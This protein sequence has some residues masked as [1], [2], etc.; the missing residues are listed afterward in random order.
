MIAPFRS[1]LDDAEFGHPL[2]IRIWIP[3]SDPDL[4]TQGSVGMEMVASW[5][6]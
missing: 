1:G 2:L 5:V 4:D 6:G 3:P